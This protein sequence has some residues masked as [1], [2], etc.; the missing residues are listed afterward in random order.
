M[1]DLRPFL[2]TDPVEESGFA[3]S[4]EPPPI[5]MTCECVCTVEDRET[6]RMRHGIQK[7]E[8]SPVA[9]GN[10][11]IRSWFWRCSSCKR[12]RFGGRWTE[13]DG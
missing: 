2:E 11:P 5:T 4:G 7:I 9:I 13:D 6:G 12:E 1:R 8:I 10:P 3:G